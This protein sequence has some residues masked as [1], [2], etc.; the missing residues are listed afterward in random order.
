MMHQNPS[1]LNI[2]N[3]D[4]NVMPGSQ[5]I[6]WDKDQQDRSKSPYKRELLGSNLGGIGDNLQNG[7]D[8]I[9]SELNTKIQQ[10]EMQAQEIQNK[11][12]QQ[13]RD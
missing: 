2:G 7:N 12:D 11:V 8:D 4:S 13:E 3:R 1:Y 10:L 6:G 9:A 5:N